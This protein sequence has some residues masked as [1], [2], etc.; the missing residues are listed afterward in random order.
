MQI[1]IPWIP[2]TKPD[3]LFRKLVLARRPGLL[4]GESMP[5]LRCVAQEV[6]VDESNLAE[7]RAVTASRDSES[8]P[9][10]YPH[11]MLGSAHLAL[12]SDPRF[13]L[14]AI[15]ML[16]LR[17]HIIRHRSINPSESF[18]VS[19]GLG[20]HRV[21]DKGLEFDVDTVLRVKGDTVWESVSTLFK[22]GRFGPADEPSPWTER[23]EK[24][25]G[26]EIAS[27]PV[28]TDV[29]K[30]YARVSGDHNP[31]HVSRVG[32][33]LFGFRTTIAHGMWTAARSLAAVVPDGP[34]RIDVAFKGPMFSGSR[35]LVM[36]Q[37]ERIDVFC[38]S[39]PR[40]VIQMI[41]S[42]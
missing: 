25:E 20:A 7:Y 8:M 36:Q 34:T 42:P 19:C 4:P 2:G 40:P 3:R 1:D 31:I 39:N 11:V 35:A 38:A 13:P 23:F 9:L 10:F 21:T 14:R 15:G 32:A 37:A 18:D 28:A 29:G 24:I 6:M 5:R 12:V 27:F 26:S 22:R 17:N 33:R 30:Q 41:V 16:H